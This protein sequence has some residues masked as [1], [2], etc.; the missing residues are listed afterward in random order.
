M[1]PGY[2]PYN[3]S[4][5]E[6]TYE[7]PLEKQSGI[8][9]N[10]RVNILTPDTSRLFAMY[11][12]IPASQCTTL[13]NPTEGLWDETDLS[14]GF[15]S[16]QNIQT[17][18][19]AIRAGVYEKSN[20]QFVIGEQDCDS[21]KIV[22]RSIFLQYA[23]NLP[24]DTQNQ[25]MSLNTMVLNYCIPQVFSEAQGYMQY[26]VDASTMYTPIAHPIQSKTNDKE[27]VLKP[28]F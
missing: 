2:N 19:N 16:R 26:L 12:K 15:F 4:R 6:Q 11:D 20:G 5:T 23:S 21:L 13:R 24:Y 1:N 25:I 10:G 18:Q 27:L 28:W 9:I 14:S 7:T 22:M 8:P 3:S 17:L